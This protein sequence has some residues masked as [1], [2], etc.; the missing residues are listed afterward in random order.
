MRWSELSADLTTWT[1]PKERAKNKLAHEVQLSP[2]AVEILKGLPRKTVTVDGKEVPSDFVFTTT[3]ATPFASY[4]KA[5]ARLDKNAEIA[6]WGLHDL[7]RT[8]TTG[9]ASIGIAP[10]IAD[11]ILNHKTGTIKGV[12]AVYNR[13]AYTEERRNALEAWANR[14]DRVVNGRADNVVELR[15]AQ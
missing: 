8:M 6:P 10:H 5:K 2:A 9:L 7:R 1:I 4:S 11:K 14:L 12:A 3:G 15:A 13:H